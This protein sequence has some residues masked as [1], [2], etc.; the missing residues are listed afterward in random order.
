VGRVLAIAGAVLA[1]AVAP[2]VAAAQTRPPLTARVVSCTT[3]ASAAERAAAF[4]ATMRA[5]A[6]SAYMRMRFDLLEQPI[7]SRAYTRVDL[8]AWTGWE[9]SEPGRPALIW[10]R[11]VRGLRAGV[12][13]RARVR[14]RWY[15]A[16]GS[17]LRRASRL[18]PVCRQPETP[19]APAPQ[20]SG[21]AS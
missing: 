14:F 12:E 11:R 7:G 1:C 5:I 4:S 2:S 9:R 18:T 16:D 20:P 10:T 15:D 3:G 17:V 6:G 19:G 21:A 8:P 13:Y